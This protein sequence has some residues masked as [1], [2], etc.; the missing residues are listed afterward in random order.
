[1]LNYEEELKKFKPSLEVEEIG[2][3]RSSE[4]SHGSEEMTFV[5]K[6]VVSINGLREEDRIPVQLLV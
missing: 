4:T 6:I 1:M 2:Y 5:R 3:D